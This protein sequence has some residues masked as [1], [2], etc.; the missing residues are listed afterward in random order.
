MNTLLRRSGRLLFGRIMPKFAYPF[1]FG[2]LR[3]SRFILGS[4]AGDSGGASVY[5]N[6]TEPEQSDAMIREL[7][8]GRVFF[9]IGANVGYYTILVSRVVGKS[10]TVLAFEPVI[11]NLAYLQQHVV[12]NKASNVRI[13]P[14]A[15]SNENG[16]ARFSLGPNSAMGG[17]ISD[18]A[19]NAGDILVPTVTMDKIA[20]ELG[21]APDVL[22]IDVEGAEINVLQG[23]MELLRS[24]KPVI[25]LSTHSPGLREECLDLLAEVGYEAE[26]LVPGDD[27]H[28]FLLEVV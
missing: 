13:L 18:D 12:L 27:P 15:C 16:I 22:K 14:F 2:P 26:P 1:V 19:A 28:E 8:N 23:E 17:L 24:K 9:D 25:F 5:F 3:S 21:I 20:E 4:L 10:G 11:R 7:K 6:K